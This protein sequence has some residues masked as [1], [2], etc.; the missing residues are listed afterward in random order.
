MSDTGTDRTI[1]FKEFLASQEDRLRAEQTAQ[2]RA[3][4]TWVDAVIGLVDQI[5]AWVKA[6]DPHHL[7]GIEHVFGDPDR[8]PTDVYVRARLDIWVGSQK[9]SI[10]PVALNVLGP[11]WKPGMG[12]WAGQVDMACEY[13]GHEIFRFLHDDGRQEWYLRNTRDYQLR[14]LDQASFDAALVAALS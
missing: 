2:S 10:R 1:S 9:V 11:R 13:Y 3:R 8:P 14:L 5:E 4:E 12:R 6:S 7:V